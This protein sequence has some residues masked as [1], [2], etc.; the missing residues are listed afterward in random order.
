MGALRRGDTTRATL[1]AALAWSAL[2]SAPEAGSLFG[3]PLPAPEPLL[4]LTVLGLL[5]L[6][7]SYRGSRKLI[8]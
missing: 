6:L 5:A 1:A 8:P 7:S 4:A 2:A 3:M